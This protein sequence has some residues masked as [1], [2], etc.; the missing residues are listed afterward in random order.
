MMHFGEYWL[1]LKLKSH[2]DGFVPW[3]KLCTPSS[4]QT[5]ETK[6]NCINMDVSIYLSI[7]FCKFPVFFFLAM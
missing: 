1:S 4:L 3:E 5:K 7:C 2:F 6:L